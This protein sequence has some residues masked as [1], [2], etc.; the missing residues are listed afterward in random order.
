MTPKVSFTNPRLGDFQTVRPLG[1]CADGLT[2]DRPHDWTKI[3]YKSRDRC[4]DKNQPEISCW[5]RA[6]LA[7]LTL[8]AG[9]SFRRR[10]SKLLQLRVFLGVSVGPLPLVF[11]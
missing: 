2:G 11:H 1:K 8:R 7:A 4:L 6:R 9:P 5:K 3:I 10:L